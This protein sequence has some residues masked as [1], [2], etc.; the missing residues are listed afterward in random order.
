LAR[1]VA[2]FGFHFLDDLFGLLL[3]LFFQPWFMHVYQ[4]IISQDQQTNAKRQDREFPQS[5]R[6]NEVGIP[7]KKL[8][9]HP[10]AVG[11]DPKIYG[12]Q[13]VRGRIWS[14]IRFHKYLREIAYIF[15][16]EFQ[17]DKDD[18]I[19]Y[20]NGAEIIDEIQVNKTIEIEL[21]GIKMAAIIGFNSARTAKNKPTTL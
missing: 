18:I 5:I 7:S 11:R 1:L 14:F 21:A 2:A 15:C 3:N 8:A 12:E 16:E 17:Y 13:Y 19:E 10:C 6:P 20:S 9:N 4:V